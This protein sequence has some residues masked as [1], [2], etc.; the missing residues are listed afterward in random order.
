MA[1]LVRDYP[2]TAHM[3]RDP[4]EDGDQFGYSVALSPRE[5]RWLG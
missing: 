4:A 2:R 1:H 5:L 3:R